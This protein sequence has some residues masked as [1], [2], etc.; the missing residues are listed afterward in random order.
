MSKQSLAVKYR[1]KR[2]NEVVE[3]DVTKAIL[4]EQLKDKSFK[5]CL[6]FCGGAGTGKAQPLYSKI[7]TPN[8][9]I[10][11]GDVKIGTVV[12][13][14]KG[15]PAIVTGVYPQ[16]LKPVY[17]ITLSDKTT[18]RVSDEHLNVVYKYDES[19]N[20]IYSTLDTNTV[21]RI[22]DIKYT[23]N[24]YVDIP[25]VQF[26]NNPYKE[27]LIHPYL[28]G[29]LIGSGALS[30]NTIIFSDTDKRVV[31]KVD[32]LLRKQFSLCLTSLNNRPNDYYIH[33]VYTSHKYT[34]R[35][36]NVD[37]HGET[38]IIKELVN[39][40]YPKFSII[41]MKSIGAG[42]ATNTFRKYPELKDDIVMTENNNYSK[43]RTN[44]LK[45]LINDLNLNCTAENKFIPE[46][47][48]Y[49]K[50][51]DRISLLN[52]LLDTDGYID[53]TDIKIDVKSETLSDNIAFLVRSLG[54]M[55]IIK[56]KNNKYIHTITLS[57]RIKNIISP[58]TDNI[59]VNPERYITD[60]SLLS[61]HEECQCI[62]VD[63][64]DH[65]Y[66]SDNFI[67]T[68]NTT[69]ARIFANEINDFK[70]HPIE[71]DAASNNSVDDIRKIIDDSA[72]QSLDSEYKVYVID[73]CHS[74]SNQAW[75]AFL[76]LLEEP[77]SK[78]VYILSTTN[79]EKIPNTILSRVQRFN[80]QKISQSGIIE[81]LK[82][83][84]DSE[85]D[86]NK[87]ENTPL[88]SYEDS[89]IEFIAKQS[90]GGM[91]D[92]ITLLDKSIGYNNNLTL[93]NV[94]KALG[95]VNYDTMFDLTDALNVMDKKQVIEIIESVHRSGLDL[96]QFM[97]QYNYFTLDLCKY[98]IFRTFDFLQLP[99]LYEDKL[100]AY[101][102][103]DFIFFK[104]LMEE[105]LKL[106]KEIKYETVPKPLIETT[107]LLLCETE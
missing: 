65:T 66:I 98:D 11:M 33:S 22:F 44:K 50:M 83:I 67:P 45:I 72:Y 25:E 58:E 92:A 29:A 10:T 14:R 26:E 30:K 24:I 86:I 104:Q 43:E 70:G 32:S 62:Y 81:R 57:E 27:F 37:Y 51:E 64:V 101:S 9:Y 2:F 21:K 40:G 36:H 38:A 55:D 53:N 23:E 106:N 61:E 89:A 80:F 18:I 82:Y 34:Y 49:S 84:I 15:N 46:M 3:Q 59:K 71:L 13:T 79:P 95:A 52:G 90:D 99:R 48:L 47:Y 105:V 96:K 107:L 8:G 93:E 12:Y 28:L 4:C 56:T 35:Y 17:E 100:N 74:L 77:P 54:G 78:S 60:I 91:R 73:E 87:T 103:N 39:R 94:L 20:R 41:T 31:N 6:L 97:T 5:N 76:K 85:N 7:L 88:I 16:G 69:S 42:T 1:P 75:Q 19:G 63:D 102:D 68:H